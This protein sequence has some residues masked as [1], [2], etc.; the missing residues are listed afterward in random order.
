MHTLNSSIQFYVASVL[1]PYI[2]HT[3]ILLY[4]C[5]AEVREYKCHENFWGSKTK[6]YHDCSQLHDK[7]FF[8]FP[9][10]KIVPIRCTLSTVPFNFML[11][12][13][14]NLISIILTSS[15]II[16]LL[17]FVNINATKTFGVLRLNIIMFMLS[18]FL[19]LIVYELLKH[20]FLL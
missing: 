4:H 13:Y 8:Q 6:H 2:Y 7:A 9:K 12:L 19:L 20:E 16:V 10:I 15:S 14:S 17:K 5:T 18:L 11:L 3:D 1:Q